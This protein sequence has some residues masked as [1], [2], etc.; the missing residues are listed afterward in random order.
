[1]EEEKLGLIFRRISHTAKKDTDNYL[2]KWDLTMSQAMILEYLNNSP[3]KELTQRAIEQHF[4]LQ[5][6][7]VSGILKRLEKHGFITT[8]TNEADR[9]VKDIFTTEKAK[10]LDTRA[11]MHQDEM[12]AVY[13]RGFSQEEAETLRKLLTRVLGNLSGS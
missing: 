13:V 6:P 11:K 5:H 4:N 12:E 2:K 9:R 10:Q 1:M 3:D 7:T 8:A